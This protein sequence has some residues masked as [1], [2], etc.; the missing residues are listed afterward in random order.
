MNRKVIRMLVLAA[1][2]TAV[3]CCAG[4]GGSGT[5][6]AGIPDGAAGLW[7]CEPLASDGETDTSFYALR[8]EESGEFS[9]Y[10]IAAGNPGIAG[11]MGNVTDATLDMQF[12]TEEDFD[13]PFCWNLDVKPATMQYELS[14]GT[15]KLGYDDVWLTFHPNQTQE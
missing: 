4:C 9:L 5:V 3:F 12:N 6:S 13:P 2:L 14:D 15:F 8:V 10:D 11:T 1:V 7:L